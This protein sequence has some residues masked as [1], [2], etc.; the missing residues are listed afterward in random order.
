MAETLCSL[1][2]MHAGVGC[3][4]RLFLYI[5]SVFEMN[6]PR[7]YKREYDDPVK[8]NE[9]LI[10]CIGKL[11]LNSALLQMFSVHKNTIHTKQ[12]TSGLKE[13]QL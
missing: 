7:C 6:E 4:T 13:E 3:A 5:A 8:N 1:R 10:F 12:I 11:I 9:P 2:R